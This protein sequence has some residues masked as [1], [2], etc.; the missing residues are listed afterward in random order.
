MKVKVTCLERE[1]RVPGFPAV[2]VTAPRPGALD[3]RDARC[4]HL[5]MAS[6]KFCT[7]TRA[8]IDLETGGMQDGFHV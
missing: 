2:F 5:G 6:S 7:A 4:R 3:T 1:R 8:V